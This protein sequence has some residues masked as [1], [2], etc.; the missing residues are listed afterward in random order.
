MRHEVHC[1]TALQSRTAA[2]ASQKSWHD[3]A[4]FLERAD[5]MRVL[6]G[7]LLLTLATG[8]VLALGTDSVLVLVRAGLVGGI[9]VVMVID[10]IGA[11]LRKRQVKEAV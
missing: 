10:A 11:V 1:P 7:L 3:R 8:M 9:G 2:A 5:V 6:C 4:V